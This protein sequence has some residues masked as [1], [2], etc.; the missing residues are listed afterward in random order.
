MNHK[1]SDNVL[2]IIAC[3]HCGSSLHSLNQ[4]VTCNNCQ[5]HYGRTK[6]G[7]IDFRLQKQKKYQYDFQLGTQLLPDSGFDFGI[8][9]KKSNPEVDFSKQD[10][11]SHL[12]RAII[13][14][15]PK[16]KTEN[17]LMLDLGCGNM[18][19]KDV[20]EYAGFEHV[21]LDYDSDE[22]LMLG[23]AHALPF[24]DESFEFILSIAVLEHIRF[25]FV[26]MKEVHRVLKPNGIFIGTVAFLEPFHGDSFYHHTHLGVYNSLQEGGFRIDRICPD[27]NWSVLMAQAS[28]GLFPKMPRIISRSLVMPIQIIHKIWWRFASI[29]SNKATEEA[30]IRN[31]TGV[32]TFIAHK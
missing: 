9:Q 14:H 21:G 5:L 2:K 30:R 1:I 22:A 20:C 3:P 10:I 4:N 25:P 28:M 27:D 12:S 7:S 19:H 13:S 23:D 29:F 11:P 15:F 8:F 26:A 32:F 31:T 17:S 16:A 24:K 18:V 6:S